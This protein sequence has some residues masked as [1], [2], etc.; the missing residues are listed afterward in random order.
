MIPVGMNSG[1]ESV[2][3]THAQLIAQDV[4]DRIRAYSTSNNSSSQFYFGPYANGVASFFFYNSDGARSSDYARTGELVRVSDSN[5]QP[6]HYNDPGVK[7]AADFYRAKVVVNLFDQSAGYN[8][9]DPRLASGGNANLLCVSVEIGW[10]I[11]RQDGSLVGNVSKKCLTPSC[12]ASHEIPS[13]MD[14]GIHSCRTVD[15]NHHPCVNCPASYLG[16][17]WGQPSLDIRRATGFTV[18]GWP[19]CS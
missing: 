1:R 9:T 18:S 3:A 13:A 14:R 4:F 2:D 11:N 12:F 8:S 17:V 6:G 10:P 15:R 5:D 16:G 7:T 19:R